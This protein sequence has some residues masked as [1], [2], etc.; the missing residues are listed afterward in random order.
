MSRVRRE[1]LPPF[2]QRC[3]VIGAI[4]G[5]LGLI[6]FGVPRTGMDPDA[7]GELPYI[8][9]G[10]FG[11]MLGMYLGVCVGLILRALGVGGRMSGKERIALVFAILGPVA[12]FVAGVMIEAWDAPW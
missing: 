1:P 12:V 8:R 7:L 6:A 5:A 10:I 2:Y 11:G 3:I 9:S 4:V